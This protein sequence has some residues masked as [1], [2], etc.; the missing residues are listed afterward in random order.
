MEKVET[1][2]TKTMD[3]LKQKL[4][5]KHVIVDRLKAENAA[6]K[7]GCSIPSNTSVRSVYRVALSSVEQDR[8]AEVSSTETAVPGAPVSAIL[9]S[10][11][12]VFIEPAH[13]HEG[14]PPL[15]S[16]QLSSETTILCS[17]IPSPG[18]EQA[19][20]RRIVRDIEWFSSNESLAGES[21]SQYQASDT[22]SSLHALWD[23]PTGR[24]TATIDSSDNS[25]GSHIGTSARRDFAV[26]PD[27]SLP[28][29]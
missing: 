4:I 28:T 26:E 21:D 7:V 24:S 25:Y 2:P 23:A 6:R 19:F 13:D 1:W 3:D 22:S 10:S 8:G 29:R 9:P 12:F 5:E 20:Y 16:S 14:S 27:N 15:Q 11:P 18:E 17:A